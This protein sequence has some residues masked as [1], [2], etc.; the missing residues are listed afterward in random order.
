[1][2]TLSKFIEELTQD[3]YI[4]EFNVR[5]KQMMLPGIKHKWAGRQVRA[6][7]ELRSL[8]AKKNKMIDEY[9]DKLIQESPVKLSRP[10]AESRVR[11]LDAVKQ[12]DEQ[13]GEKELVIEFLEKTDRTLSS[14]TFDIKNLC[15]IMKL[16]MQ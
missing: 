4:D 13:I 9:T 6:K 7:F 8:Y 1:M 12:I 16:E 14:M 5:E 3:V 15:D 2:D 11:D 10:V